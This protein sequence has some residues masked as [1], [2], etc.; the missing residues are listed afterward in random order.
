MSLFRILGCAL[1]LTSSLSAG[2]GIMGGA[3]GGSPVAASSGDVSQ[4]TEAYAL[5]PAAYVIHI[6]SGDAVILDPLAADFPLFC[7]VPA[8]TAAMQK[9]QAAGQLPRGEW[10]VY[11]VYGEWSEI[12]AETEPGQFRLIK[13]APLVDWVN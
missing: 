3:D 12:A 10:K 2:C 9:A 4:C 11:R 8:A 6:V 5:A 13:A 7:D 1:L